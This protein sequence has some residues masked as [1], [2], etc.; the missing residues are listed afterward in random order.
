MQA[1]GAAQDVA[2]ASV[3]VYR[4]KAGE[5][6]LPVMNRISAADELAFAYSNPSGKKRLMIYAVDE[7][8]H[9][10]W[11]HPAWL[12]ATTD[13]VAV[14]IVA[15]AKSIE[16]PE[17]VGH[18]LSQGNLDIRWLFVDE[19]LSVTQVEALLANQASSASS[20]PIADAVQGSL[21]VEVQPVEVQP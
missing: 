18:E 13:P 7:Q 10:F 4:I 1:R 12:D 5:K 8:K 6:P 20:L 16:L 17:A 11:Y 9:V 3:V 2:K 19:A 14:P 21:H 15:G